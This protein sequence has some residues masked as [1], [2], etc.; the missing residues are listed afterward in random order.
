MYNSV[1]MTDHGYYFVLQ[2]FSCYTVK[3]NY[4]KPKRRVMPRKRLT[5][6]FFYSLLVSKINF[7]TQKLLD[8]I[9]KLTNEQATVYTYTKYGRGYF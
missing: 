8:D 4:L 9:K 2:Q 5:W 7:F 1:D 3:Q 6:L